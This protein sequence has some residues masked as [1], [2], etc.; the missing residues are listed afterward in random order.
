MKKLYSIGV[1]IGGTNTDIGLVDSEG[2]CLEMLRIK[3]ALFTDVNLYVDALI[4]NIR[5]LI[6]KNDIPEITGIGIG[7]PN[8][9]YYTGCVEN[10]VNL[11]FKGKIDLRKLIQKSIPVEVI[12]TNDANAAAYGEMIYGGAKKMK[13]FIMF[14]IGTGVGSGIVVDGKLVYGHDGNAGEIGH[15][16]IFPEGR[17]CNCGRKGCLEQYTSARG[18][19][20]TCIEMMKNIDDHTGLEDVISHDYG[21]KA[22]TKAAMN[23]NQLANQVLAK[24]GEILGL[25]LANSVAYTSPEAIFLMGGP[26]KAGNI[27]LDPIRKSFDENLLSI[28]KGKTQILVSKLKENEAAILGAAALTNKV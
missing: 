24:T 23:G 19:R 25:A 12:V 21:F 4:N 17:P 9:N 28:Y 5:L 14:T 7:V 27:L 6:T 13:N 10:A 15:T 11:N 2:L 16:I 3:T 22:I 26:L 1:D 18:I 20:K 8:G